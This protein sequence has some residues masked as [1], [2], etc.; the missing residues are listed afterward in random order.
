MGCKI[1]L[2]RLLLNRLDF[3]QEKRVRFSLETPS[4][5]DVN[6]LKYLIC[7]HGLS[8]RS[9]GLH[10]RVEGWTPSGDAKIL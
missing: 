9:L 1:Y 7:L 6:D 5:I 4:F 2:Y 10:P 3:T 8:Q